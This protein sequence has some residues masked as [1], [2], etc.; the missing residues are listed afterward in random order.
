MRRLA[1]P[2]LAVTPA[3]QP[4]E[5]E[6]IR[7][8]SQMTGYISSVCPEQMKIY[9]FEGKEYLSETFVYFDGEEKRRLEDLQTNDF[10]Q[11]TE[12]NKTREE[13]NL[14]IA[15]RLFDFYC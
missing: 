13:G 11:E 8:T 1:R 4:S 15:S 9:K 10:R 3:I 5:S 2:S 14:N 6:R 7:I 12:Q